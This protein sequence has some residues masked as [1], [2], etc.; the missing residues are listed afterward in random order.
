MDN[1]SASI[2]IVGVGAFTF[3]TPTRFF[4]N[5]LNDIVGFSRAGTSGLDLFNGP[6]DSQFGTWDMLSGIGPVIGQGY[7]LQWSDTPM[8]TDKG[9]LAFN[10]APT[11]ALF[12]ADATAPIP[13]PGAAV[14]LT[15]GLAAAGFLVRKRRV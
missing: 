8:F 14:L 15:M 9:I 7:L 6:T 13:E 12:E 2:D 3:L 5:N 11:A 4:V 10:T 1:F